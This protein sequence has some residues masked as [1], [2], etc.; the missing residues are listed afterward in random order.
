MQWNWLPLL[1][2]APWGFVS[3]FFSCISA[4]FAIVLFTLTSILHA[5]S[6]Q[7]LLQILG[8]KMLK[9]FMNQHCRSSEWNLCIQV[10]F[11]RFFWKVNIFFACEVCWK[12][13]GG[14]SAL[15]FF[16]GGNTAKTPA[17]CPATAQQ[18]L[19]GLLVLFLVNLWDRSL[20]RTQT[21][22]LSCL[23]GF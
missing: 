18:W 22:P 16:V 15:S 12:R 14:D 21:A 3:L 4:V 23:L 1:R 5:P 13:L 17:K 6:D 7:V 8:S 20:Y 2:S 10:F 11:W 9:T 19:G